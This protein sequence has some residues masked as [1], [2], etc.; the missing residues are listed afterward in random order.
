MMRQ[1]RVICWFPQSPYLGYVLSTRIIFCAYYLS[2]Y[3]FIVIDSMVC[4]I[5]EM[6]VHVIK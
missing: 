1:Q 6:Q 2:Y 3:I 5:E 4:N